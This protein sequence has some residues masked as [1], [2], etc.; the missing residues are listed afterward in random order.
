MKAIEG[1]LLDRDGTPLLGGANDRSRSTYFD[2]QLKR[3]SFGRRAA[4]GA[5]LIAAPLAVFAGLALL[6]VIVAVIAAFFLIGALVRLIG[7][8]SVVRTRTIVVRRS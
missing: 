3:G 8:P 1:I 7:G 6:A 4:I 5:A 2:P